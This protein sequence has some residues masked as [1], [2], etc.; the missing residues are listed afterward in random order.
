MIGHSLLSNS[1]SLLELGLSGYDKKKS[2][3]GSR[4]PCENN[5]PTLDSFLRWGVV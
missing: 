2:F 1:I 5:K 4:L 3:G